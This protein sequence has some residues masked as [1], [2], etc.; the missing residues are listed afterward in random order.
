[1]TNDPFD[2]TEPEAI[3]ARIA[4]LQ[5]KLAAREGIKQFDANCEAIRNEIV[6]LEALLPAEPEPA[7]EA[8]AI[9]PE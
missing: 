9:D 8:S 5:E 2:P 7:E 6:R 1:M 3:R 4:S